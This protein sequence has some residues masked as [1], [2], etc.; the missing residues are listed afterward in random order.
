MRYSSWLIADI[1]LLAVCLVLLFVDAV[2]TQDTVLALVALGGVFIFFDQSW[3]RCEKTQFKLTGFLYQ[4]TFCP[5][6]SM[7]P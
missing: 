6:Y 3:Q 7:K 4:P 5:R 1:L 2:I